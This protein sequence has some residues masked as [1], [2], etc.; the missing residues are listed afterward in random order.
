MP[1]GR[2]ALV[3]AVENGRVEVVRALLNHQET[4]LS[5]NQTMKNLKARLF[6]MDGSELSTEIRRLLLAK[7]LHEMT[8][9][10]EDHYQR[11]FCG[12]I[13]IGCSAGEKH[14]AALALSRMLE[15]GRIAPEALAEHEKA[16]SS[17]RLATIFEICK[18]G[19]ASSRGAPGPST[20]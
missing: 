5:D 20:E 10:H 8:L 1:D 13:A 14:R 2:T 9:R 6:G 19:L 4:T 3:I 11:I 16:L 7:Y 18:R 12:M 17:G 15:S